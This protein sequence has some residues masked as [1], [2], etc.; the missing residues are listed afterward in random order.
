M[1]GMT[2]GDREKLIRI[3][4][5]RATLAKSALAG[6]ASRGTPHGRGRGRVTAPRGAAWAVIGPDGDL[7]WYPLTATAEVERIVSGDYAPGALDR[8]FVSGPVRV[9]A[10]D[11]ALLAPEHYPANPVARPLITDLSGGRIAQP[12]RGHVALVEYDRD[13]GTREWLW[14]CEMSAEWSARIVASHRDAKAA[15]RE[16]SPEKT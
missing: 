4:R 1:T 15:L 5:K 3:I 8:A 6:R 2:S 16:P 9:M 10:S 11:V 13:P 12:W 7:T 14:P